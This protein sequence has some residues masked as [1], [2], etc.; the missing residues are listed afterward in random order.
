MAIV[1]SPSQRGRTGSSRG[2]ACLLHLNVVER[3]FSRMLHCVMLCILAFGEY[4]DLIRSQKA[5]KSLVSYPMRF[6]CC[7]LVSIAFAPF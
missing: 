3:E 5:I 2:K 7:T 4:D 1:C 6:S